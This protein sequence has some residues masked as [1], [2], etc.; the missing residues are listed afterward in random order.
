MFV[1]W[2]GRFVL[3]V[4]EQALACGSEMLDS[5]VKFMIL[6]ETCYRNTKR[7]KIIETIHASTI[8]AAA[9]IYALKMQVNSRLKPINR[10][11]C[12]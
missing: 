3:V 4:V 2:R 6:D 8:T 10:N 5:Q 11:I 7:T 12:L 9:F 1:V